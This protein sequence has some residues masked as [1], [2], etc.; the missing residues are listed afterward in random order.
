MQPDDLVDAGILC[1][2]LNAVMDALNNLDKQAK[3]LKRAEARRKLSPRLAGQGVMRINL[4]PSHREN[5]ST[6]DEIDM[7]EILRS[8]QFFA[9]EWI[10][11]Q[12]TS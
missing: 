7:D 12:D 5:G 8:L 10:A 9:R 6:P 11:A 4:P 3:R 1:Q 2:R